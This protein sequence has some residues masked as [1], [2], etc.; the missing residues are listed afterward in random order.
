MTLQRYTQGE[1]AYSGFGGSQ[2]IGGSLASCSAWR[3]SHL[4]RRLRRPQSDEGAKAALLLI[5]L[6]ISY[7]SQTHRLVDRHC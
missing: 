6:A 3:M 7:M 2:M 4:N 1:I 5:A